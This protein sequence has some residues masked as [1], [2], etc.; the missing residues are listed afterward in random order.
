MTERSPPASR[1]IQLVYE[2][3]HLVI[4]DKP[5]GLLVHRGWANDD[6]TALFRVRDKLGSF[7]HAVH[8]LDRGTSGALLFARHQDAQR[9]LSALFEAGLVRKSYLALV[10][11]VP[12]AAGTIDYPLPREENGAE[13]V[14][15]VTHFRVLSTSPRERC[16]LVEALP[17]TGRLHQI[18]RHLCHIGHPLVGDVNHGRG[19]INR[20][21]RAEYDLHRLALHAHRLS[22][23]HPL[24][25]A[26]HLVAVEVAL[27]PDLAGAFERLGLAPDVPTS[28]S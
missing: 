19:D 18:R 20:K 6:D 28:R 22:F 27:P 16:S 25:G 10:R 8:R 24:D 5:S 2:D 7:V 1:D 13:R 12:P 23:D 15:A 21:Y 11:G 14:P 26:G 4:A 17:Q 9:R 3:A